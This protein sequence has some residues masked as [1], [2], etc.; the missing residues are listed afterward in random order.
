MVKAH[1][2]LQKRKATYTEIEIGNGGIGKRMNNIM[3]LSH[4]LLDLTYQVF[5]SFAPRH[6]IRKKPF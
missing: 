2:V 3:P 1:R 5:C 6:L 4:A